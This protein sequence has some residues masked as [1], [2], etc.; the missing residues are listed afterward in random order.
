MRRGLTICLRLSLTGELEA[1]PGGGPASCC[2]EISPF[3]G[4]REAPCAHTMRLREPA[5]WAAESDGKRC[6]WGGRRAALSSW[7]RALDRSRACGKLCPALGLPVRAERAGP[8]SATPRPESRVP[9]SSISIATATTGRASGLRPA[10][11]RARAP[12]GE[13]DPDGPLGIHTHARETNKVVAHLAL[14][15]SPRAISVIGDDVWVSV[16]AANSLP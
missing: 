13:R 11:G 5:A 1:G 9:A 2:L 14:P 16:A 3:V 4:R 7:L 10:H 15:V 8:L 12:V 6:L